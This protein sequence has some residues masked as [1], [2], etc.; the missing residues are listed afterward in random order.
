MVGLARSGDRYA[1][2]E[3]VRRRQGSVRGL[4][5]RCC[6]DPVLA[7]DLAQQ[8]FLQVWLKIRGLKEPGAFGGWLRKLAISVWLMQKRKHDPL[9]D[10]DDSVNDPV[11]PATN[12]ALGLDLD[13]AL[14]QLPDAVRLAVVLSY[15]EG[16]SHPEIADAIGMPVGTVKSHINRG[17][18]RLRA[19]LAEYDGDEVTI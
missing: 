12:P 18:K 17:S 19:L 16:M 10:A 9:G 4:M 8:V 14:A 13:Q 1:F 15:Q 5:R 2:E 7:D 3:L 6:R 11:A